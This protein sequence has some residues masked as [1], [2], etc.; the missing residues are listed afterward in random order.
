MYSNLTRWIPKVIR[1]YLNVKSNKVLDLAEL[2]YGL[3][4]FRSQGNWREDSQRAV[5]QADC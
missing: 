1:T 2:S 3:L 5:L 4:D